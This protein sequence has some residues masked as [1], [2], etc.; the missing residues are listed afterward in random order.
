VQEQGRVPFRFLFYLSLTSVGAAS[1][2][3]FLFL[4]DPLDWMRLRGMQ[5][6]HLLLMT[7]LLIFAGRFAIIAATPDRDSN[8]DLSIYREVGELT[9]HGVDPYNT[10]DQKELREK[11]KSNKTGAEEIFI[12]DNY[13]HYVSANLPGSTVLYALI[14][15]VSRGNPKAWRAMLIFGDISI[16]LASFFFLR[17]VGLKLLKT[18]HQI[19][20]FVSVAAWPS[21]IEWG[22][23]WPEEKQF[24]TALMLLLAGLFARSPKSPIVSAVTIGVIGCLSVFFK[25]F[26]IFLLPAALQYFIKRPRMEFLTATGVFLA[27]SSSFFIFFHHAFLSEMLN[28]VS[29]NS[30]T[31]AHGSPWNLL[32][33]EWVGV[34]RPTICMALVIS[35][36]LLYFRRRIDLL[37]CT[38][39]L[40]VVFA[41]LWL[42]TGSMDRMNVAM[43]FS[44]FCVATIS[45]RS[46]AGLTIFNFVAQIPFYA[47]IAIQHFRWNPMQDL[48]MLDAA[49][50]AIF[51][52]SYFSILLT[53]RGDR[54]TLSSSGPDLSEALNSQ[55]AA[56]NSR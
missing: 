32:P 1:F 45:V 15:I 44:L 22:T 7:V 52:I 3:S 30:S 41:C 43:I 34:L 20:F 49:A 26:G 25:A 40:L 39:A 46:W 11:L 54:T 8:A 29:S 27:A 2:I 10:N 48:E 12:L 6:V 14:E 42:T 28:R 24:Q 13:D 9:V 23:F 47:V 33:V 53:R 51:V 17:S 55:R 16:A 4:R 50:T 56:A 37:N 19:A 35:T 38:A 31:P 21:L 5:P 36:I 18:S